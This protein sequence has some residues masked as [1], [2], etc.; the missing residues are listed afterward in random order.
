MIINWNGITGSWSWI[1]G[2]ISEFC[3]GLVNGFKSALGIASPSKV[4][5]DHY[6]IY[7]RRR[8]KKRKEE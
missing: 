2:K 1:I 4:M 7:A 6:E 3:G 8:K 5:R